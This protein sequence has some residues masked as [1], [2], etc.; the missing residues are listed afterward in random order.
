MIFP[1]VPGQVENLTASFDTTE[2]VFDP[3]NRMYSLSIEID[4]D[5]PTFPNG[6]IVSYNVSVFRTDDTSDVVYSDTSL[7]VATV[8]DSVMVLPFTDYTVTVA[9]STSAGQG[10]ETS[11]TVESPQAGSVYTIETLYFSFLP[12]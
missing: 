10:E 12:M 7:A 5:N 4:W 8:A 3:E 1:A 2:A 11:V 9:A 6:E